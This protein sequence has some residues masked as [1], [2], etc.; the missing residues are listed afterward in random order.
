MG[1]EEEMLQ[2]QTSINKE[3]SLL[4]TKQREI[5]SQEAAINH[6]KKL[7]EKSKERKE[8]YKHDNA[9]IKKNITLSSTQKKKKI[10]SNSERIHIENKNINELRQTLEEAIKEKEKLIQSYLTPEDALARD[11][12]KKN[13]DQ[14]NEI[15]KELNKKRNNTKKSYHK[16]EIQPLIAEKRNDIAKRESSIKKI[17]QSIFAKEIQ[18]IAKYEEE[19]NKIWE[20]IIS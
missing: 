11:N 18:T 14:A 9:I 10:D 19:K 6:I 1:K 4:Q 16:E 5:N 3:K 12:Q 8:L 13:I 15:I 17:T 20:A 2:V 7:I